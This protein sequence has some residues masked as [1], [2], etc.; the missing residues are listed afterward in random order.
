MP[1]NITPPTIFPAH[2]NFTTRVSWIERDT[3]YK[4]SQSSGVDDWEDESSAVNSFVVVNL[5]P[6]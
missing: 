5:L 3:T 1:P 2:C 6:A 4:S